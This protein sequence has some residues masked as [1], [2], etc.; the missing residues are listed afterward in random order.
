MNE[1]LH[2]WVGSTVFGDSYWNPDI[3][4]LEVIFLHSVHL[5]PNTVYND[6]LISYDMRKIGLAGEIRKLYVCFVAKIGS[7]FDL[8]ELVV[9]KSC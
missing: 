6:V 4:F 5:G 2:I 7:W 9:P 8:L 1:S 3:R